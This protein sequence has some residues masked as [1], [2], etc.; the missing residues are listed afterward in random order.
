MQE[1]KVIDRFANEYE[2]LSNFYPVIIK[3]NNINF[4]TVEH[5]FVASKSIKPEFWYKISKLKSDQAGKAKLMGRKIYLRKDWD[6][7]KIARMKNFLLQKFSQNQFK[8]FI[9]S[10]G[11]AKLIEGNYWHDN[12]WGDCKCKK[13]KKIIGQNQLGKLL[14]T[15]RSLL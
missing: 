5:A 6:L 9:L 1:L 8:E 7:I 13:C 15:I 3:F 10:T 4:P 11:D 14:M 2:Q 12:Y